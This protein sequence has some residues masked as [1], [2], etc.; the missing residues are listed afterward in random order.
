[1]CEFLCARKTYR[2]Y[3]IEIDNRSFRGNR[4]KLYQAAEQNGG[5]NTKA[6]GNMKFSYVKRVDR[7]AKRIIRRIYTVQRRLDKL[8]ERGDKREAEYPRWGMWR[9]DWNNLN[10][11]ADRLD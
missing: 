4:S 3:V 10:A 11:C 2:F 9:C 5:R 7:L 6:K 8:P 1:M